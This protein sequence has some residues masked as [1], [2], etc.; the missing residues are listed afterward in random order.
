ML[1]GYFLYIVQIRI[2]LVFK[3]ELFYMRIIYF[4][5]TNG[6]SY[7]GKFTFAATN[8]SAWA[9]KSMYLIIFCK[10]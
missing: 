8:N 6:I 7:F 10:Y 4:L 1:F 2:R 9:R 3:W 5:R